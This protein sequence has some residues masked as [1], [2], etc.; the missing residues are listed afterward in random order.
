MAQVAVGFLSFTSF[1]RVVVLFL[2]RVSQSSK[3]SLSSKK[4][5]LVV[6][7]GL[8]PRRVC[9]SGETASRPAGLAKA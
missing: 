3:V 5:R 6:M 4:F 9:S 2:K 8:V 7:M 1:A